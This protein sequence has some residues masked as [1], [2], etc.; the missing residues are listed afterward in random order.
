MVITK[1]GADVADFTVGSLGDATLLPGASTTF[2]VTFAPGALG[3]RSAA[4]HIASND[5][6]ENPFDIG[7]TGYGRTAV[8]S[9]RFTHFGI[10]TNT[11]NA[12][13]M[14]DADGDSFLNLMEYAFKMDPNQVDDSPVTRAMTVDSVSI[15]YPRNLAATDV[16]FTIVEIENLSGPLPW[17]D[18]TVI[19]E[20]L[21]TT[22]GVE[23]VKA[24]RTL[25]PGDDQ[26]FLRLKISRNP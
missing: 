4:I 3:S 11:G 26:L 13:D 15:T 24:T 19:E 10:I 14:V 12:A 2:T 18:A 16:T 6:D 1:D 8:E 25:L 9:W 5:A 21:D 23:T 17:A 22:N 20:I 7:L